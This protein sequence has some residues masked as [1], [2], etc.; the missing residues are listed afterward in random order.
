MDRI[1]GECEFWVP[2]STPTP[3][4][5]LPPPFAPSPLAPIPPPLAILP[6]AVLRRY[7]IDQ[8]EERESVDPVPWAPDVESA[9]AVAETPDHSSSSSSFSSSVSA[10]ASSSSL[11]YEGK[12]RLEGKARERLRLP[13]WL[14]KEIPMGANY[15]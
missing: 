14:K 13:P 2:P 4:C 6:V 9:D 5:P 12:L 3:L 8:S 11:G 7:F 1:W 15:R 10:N